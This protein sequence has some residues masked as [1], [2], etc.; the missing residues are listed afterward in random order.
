M[1]NLI[2]WLDEKIP[3]L[4]QNGIKFVNGM[5]VI[6]S[7][8]LYTGIPKMVET[9]AQALCPMRNKIENAACILRQ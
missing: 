4:K 3:F 9:Y 8:A 7:K 2:R 5:P 6:P 1:N